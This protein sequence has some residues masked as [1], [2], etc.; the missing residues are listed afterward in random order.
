MREHLL[1]YAKFVAGTD[2]QASAVAA[3]HFRRAG[4][5]VERMSA[6]EPLELAKLLE[7]TYF[8]VLL[9]WAQ[10][11]DR[12]ASAAGA[13]YDEVT[14]FFAE[15]DFFPPVTFQPG[16]I[17]G[18]CVIPNSH[19][20]DCLRPSPLVLAMRASNDERAREWKAA[21]R[22]LA[23]RLAPEPRGKGASPP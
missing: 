5:R 6:P 18:H 15:V 2:E 10:E 20:L 14:R 13:R 9:A 4:L 12:F 11:M 17:G 8:G 22:S 16:Y 3:E 21:G 19:L 7:T 1:H 23:G